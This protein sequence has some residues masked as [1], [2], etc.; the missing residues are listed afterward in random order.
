MLA[1]KETLRSEINDRNR[2]G[3]SKAETEYVLAYYDE[4]VNEINYCN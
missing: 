2:T 1:E 3:K 4:I